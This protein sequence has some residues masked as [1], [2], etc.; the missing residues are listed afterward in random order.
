MDK[1][2]L[3]LWGKALLEMAKICQSSKTF[4]NLF[5]NGF[6]REEEKLD[7]LQERFS[8]LCRKWF[9]KEGI[10][11]FNSVMGEFYENVGVV[12][13]TQ[14]NELREKY[15]ELKVKVKDLEEKIEGWKER[16]ERKSG[17]P[18]DL[19]GEWEKAMKQYAR[20]NQEFFKEFGKFFKP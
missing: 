10:E 16:L 12:P 14:Y 19:L 2:L 3:E 11:A 18:S 1:D 15:Q 9:G 5:Q 6:A 8:E 17:L 7:P 13:R 4:F 20:V